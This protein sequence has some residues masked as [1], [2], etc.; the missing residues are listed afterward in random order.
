MW[1]SVD[2]RTSALFSLFYL[3]HAAYGVYFQYGNAKRKSNLLVLGSPPYAAYDSHSRRICG[4]LLGGTMANELRLN[5]RL[6]T[7]DG[8][9]RLRHTGLN[10]SMRHA[11]INKIIELSDYLWDYELLNQKSDIGLIDKLD[12]YLI[13]S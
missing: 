2:S 10:T 9:A 1:E 13:I 8:I 11:V 5:G 4:L 6:F 7:R 3:H 12:V